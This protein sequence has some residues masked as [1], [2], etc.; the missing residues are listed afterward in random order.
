MFKLHY[1]MTSLSP[2]LSLWTVF[3]VQ[4]LI[5][6]LISASYIV[7]FQFSLPS[8]FLLD[9]SPFIQ[10]VIW[11]KEFQVDLLLGG[12]EE[13]AV[14]FGATFPGT[15]WSPWIHNHLSIMMSD[16]LY[17]KAEL[18]LVLGDIWTKIPQVLFPG[19]ET[20]F[21]KSMELFEKYEHQRTC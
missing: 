16:N 15:E 7:F 14:V 19:A 21:C 10:F 2:L 11:Q 8:P 6:F 1:E 9:C 5:S 13:G 4:A 3:S 17:T 12:M 18:E 20:A